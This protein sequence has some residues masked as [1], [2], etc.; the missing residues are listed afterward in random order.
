MMRNQKFDA[1]CLQLSFLGW[2][3]L[4]VFTCGLAGIFWSFPYYYATEAEL[5]AVLR[6]DWSAKAKFGVRTGYENRIDDVR[7]IF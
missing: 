5:Y 3:L 1:F 7:G 2:D 4:A 6:D